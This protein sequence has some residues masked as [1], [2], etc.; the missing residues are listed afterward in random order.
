[1][2]D[3]RVT[4]G[5]RQ[6]PHDDRHPRVGEDR[7]VERHVGRLPLLGPRHARAVERQLGLVRAVV[8]GHR[9]RR[10]RRVGGDEGALQSLASQRDV[11]VRGQGDGAR[12][13]VHDDGPRLRSGFHLLGLD[14]A[15]GETHVLALDGIEGE[16]RVAGA[17]RGRGRTDRLLGRLR[18]GDGPVTGRQVRLGHR[19]GDDHHAG[20]GDLRLQDRARLGVDVVGLGKPARG[21]APSAL[22]DD[23]RG[24]PRPIAPLDLLTARHGQRGLLEALL[25]RERRQG[26]GEALLER[27]RLDQRRESGRGEARRIEVEPERQRAPLGAE[28]ARDPA[29][30]VGRRPDLAA[31][32]ER[33]AERHQAWPRHARG[34]EAHAARL[35]QVGDGHV[36][37]DA[38]LEG[39][40]LGDAPEGL[41]RLAVDQQLDRAAAGGESVEREGVQVGRLREGGS[42]Q[43]GER[44]GEKSSGHGKA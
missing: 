20:R 44:G 11:G 29:V 23:P 21:A 3:G 39:H 24:D 28:R 10:E 6:R 26:D 16:R 19:D 12:L 40:R 36:G 34:V 7:S 22:L 14:E 31:R 33:V 37:Q 8:L 1:M 27:D 5:E 15:D 17:Q 32:G 2:E 35:R 42:G 30:G 18:I 13:L 43:E 9:D 38:P 41:P 4:F 25:R